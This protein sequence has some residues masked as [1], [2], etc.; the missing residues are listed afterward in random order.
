MEGIPT[1]ARQTTQK[2]ATRP[3]RTGRKPAQGSTDPKPATTA[4]K[5]PRGRQ[6]ASKATT[7]KA[8][9]NR[10]DDIAAAAADGATPSDLTNQLQQSLDQAKPKA[11]PAVTRRTAKQIGKELATERA[12]ARQAK[13]TPTDGKAKVTNATPK[14]TGTVPSG[15]GV[16]FAGRPTSNPD[17]IAS[18]A[19]QAGLRIRKDAD[20]ADIATR[21]RATV[22]AT[23]SWLGSRNGQQPAK[24]TAK[25]TPAKAPAKPMSEWL[26]GITLQHPWTDRKP[27]YLKDRVLVVRYQGKSDGSVWT[28]LT[29]VREADGTLVPSFKDLP[30][31]YR[32]TQEVM[33]NGRKLVL[34]GDLNG[35]ALREW[36]LKQGLASPEDIATS[37]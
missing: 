17:T 22:E 27:D 29:Q 26:T 15:N 4:R 13:N 1:M 24:V 18:R 28:T 14:A 10:F 9:A 8:S 23:T 35:P 31:D 34:R 33:G 7:T 20:P 25:A 3:A 2:P 16:T 36:L 19:K 6:S 11:K 12:K 30:L 32:A 37:S 21:L 5:A